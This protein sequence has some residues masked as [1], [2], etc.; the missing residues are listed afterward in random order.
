VN[1]GERRLVF[2]EAEWSA[3]R[4]SGATVLLAKTEL[5]GSAGRTGGD[6]W[7]RGSVL[8]AAAAGSGTTGL[9]LEGSF[10]A[11]GGDTPAW[12]RFSAGGVPVALFDAAL[13]PQRTPMPG[14]PVGTLVGDR[15]L[16]GRATLLLGGYAP[17]LWAA[18]SE[19]SR[20]GWYRVL[21]IEN[22]MAF[23]AMPLMGTPRASLTGGVL[24]PLDEPF[25]KQLRAYLVVGFRP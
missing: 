4:T 21:G 24:Y 9:R 6:D 15:M 11:S 8:L 7:T 3:R 23:P 22:T 2:A 12:E 5:R 25:R 1:D 20:S 16:T 14:L 17:F 13:L 10:G 18:N 19:G